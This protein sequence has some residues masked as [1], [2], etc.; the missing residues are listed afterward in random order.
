M[1]SWRRDRSRRG[2]RSSLLYFGREWKV[3]IASALIA[4]ASATAEAVGLVL[5]ASAAEHIGASGAVDLEFGPFALNLT[6]VQALLI[7]ALLIAASGV[8]RIIANYLTIRRRALLTRRWRIQLVKGFLEADFAYQSGKRR[9]EVLETA[10]Q[11]ATSAGHVLEILANAVNSLLSMLILVAGAYALDPVVAS[12]LLVGGAG[13]LLVLRPL[14]KRA[15]RLST[16]VASIDVDFGNHLDEMVRMAKDIEVF[17]ASS[18]F[19]KT[20]AGLARRSAATSQ[21]VF[22]LNRSVPVVYQVF[23]LLLLLGALAVSSTSGPTS[24]TAIGGSALLLLRG[25]SYGQQLSSFQQNI[26]RSTPYLESVLRELDAYEARTRE[27]GALEITSVETIEF[28]SVSYAYDDGAAEAIRDISVVLK[29]PGITGLVG[30]SGSGKSTLAQLI[31]RLRRPTSGSI[32]VNGVI[33]TEFGAE[34]WRRTVSFVPQEAELIHGTVMENVGFFREWVA[35][36]DVRAAIEAVGLTSL[37]ESLPDG[38]DTIIGPSL[39]QL[40]GGQ[41]QRIGIARALVGRPS[42]FVLDEPTSALDD[43]S[44]AWVMKAIRS[45][46]ENC[47]V[48]II[49]HRA[50]TRSHCDVL[51]SLDEGRLTSIDTV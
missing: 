1:P 4:S 47:V 11:H 31:L 29:K 45:L 49:T 23:G 5:I 38:V 42:L 40:S 34:S 26:A 22:L 7:S 25:I 27:F 24:I 12:I 15:K 6:F 37:V 9:G 41:K 50:S 36:A 14:T 19:G 28:D 51:I 20:A 13:L 21:S 18:W 46:G 10:G 35:E 33:S 16:E 3:I 2:T 32:L 8:G 48:I 30:A 17:G 44:E 43:D 39:R